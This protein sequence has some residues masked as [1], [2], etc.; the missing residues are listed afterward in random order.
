MRLYKTAV[1]ECDVT[2]VELQC[3]VYRIR[4]EVQPWQ[5][6]MSFFL[7]VCANPSDIFI[8]RKIKNVRSCLVKRRSASLYV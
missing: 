1:R 3:N 6:R 4:D 2:A 5:V 8:F 7:P